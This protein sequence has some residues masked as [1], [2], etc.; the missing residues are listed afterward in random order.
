MI[1]DKFIRNIFAVSFCLLVL[2]C[3]KDG[4]YEIDGSAYPSYYIPQAPQYYYH[5]PKTYQP[6]YRP[7]SR[8]YSN[9]YRTP[10]TNYYPYYDFD[11]Y[12]VP[13]IQYRNIERGGNNS[14]VFRDKN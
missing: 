3:A 1:K 7:S 9:P 12:Y 10:P 8:R 5:Y 14:S 6:Y 2:S 4:E 11:Q 13:P